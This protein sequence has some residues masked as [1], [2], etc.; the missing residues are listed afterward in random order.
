MDKHYDIRILLDGTGFTKVTQHRT[1]VAVSTL[2][3]IT[4]KLRK[5]HDR[6]LKFLRSSFQRPGNGRN[7]LF[8]H[9][10]K[11]ARALHEL[12]IIDDYESDA[13][14]LDQSLGLRPELHD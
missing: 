12:K 8:T 14:G 7:L 3:S 1:V 13:L 2:D 6:D 11:L 4:G 5:C 10:A 9:T